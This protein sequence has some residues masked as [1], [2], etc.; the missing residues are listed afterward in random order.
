MLPTLKGCTF[1]ALS[2]KDIPVKNVFSTKRTGNMSPKFDDRKE[3]EERVREF[4]GFTGFNFE[5]R[6]GINPEHKDKIIVVGKKEAG[7]NIKCDG[8]ITTERGLTLSLC[9]ADCYPIILADME[10]SVVC[11]IHA[12]RKGAKKGI[13]R[14]GI[15]LLKTNFKIPST[16]IIVG[17]GPGIKKCCYNQDLLEDVLRQIKKEGV[18]QTNISLLNVCTCC[19]RNG[20]E[21]HLF[22]SHRRA[23]NNKEKEGRF[24]ALVSL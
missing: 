16:K 19:A 5:N 7:H 18:L 12:G 11:L 10:K 23:Q 15:K 1:D 2:L 13:I 20:D 6:V 8:L 4:C 24:I 21:S 17:V 14:K 3:V 22:D 9:P